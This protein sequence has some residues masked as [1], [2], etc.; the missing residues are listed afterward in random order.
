MNRAPANHTLRI[1]CAAAAGSLLLMLSGC[2]QFPRDPRNTLNRVTGGQ[3]I[4]GVSEN[5]PWVTA[6][7]ESFS[8]VE[9]DVLRQ[10]ASSVGA[11]ITWHQG[12]ETELVKALKSGRIDVMAAGLT[13]DSRWLGDVALTRPYHGERV[14]AV[15]RGENAFISTLERYL[16]EHRAE[17]QQTAATYLGN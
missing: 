1:L 5:P 17:I 4:V 3:L 13:K 7:G 11:D 15:P 6:E 10:F 16:T 9:P 8:G 14:M 12:T 2:E